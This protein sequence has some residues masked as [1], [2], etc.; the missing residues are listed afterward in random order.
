VFRT[1]RVILLAAVPLPSE[2]VA[3][4]GSTKADQ[5]QQ[6]KA[7]ERTL[8]DR[9]TGYEQARTEARDRLGVDFEK[10]ESKR[11]ELQTLRQFQ[12][13]LLDEVPW[14]FT[15]YTDGKPDKHEMLTFR[16]IQALVEAARDDDDKAMNK[17]LKAKTTAT[18]AQYTKALSNFTALIIDPL[19]KAGPPAGSDTFFRTYD[20]LT[21]GVKQLEQEVAGYETKL[22]DTTKRLTDAQAAVDAAA[23]T[24]AEAEGRLT[25]KWKLDKVILYAEKKEQPGGSVEVWNKQTNIYWKTEILTPTSVRN[26]GRQY[27]VTGSFTRP[28]TFLEPGKPFDVTFQ[29]SFSQ[30]EKD[31]GWPGVLLDVMGGEVSS[32]PKVGER[33]GFLKATIDGKEVPRAVFEVN[34]KRQNPSDR[35]TFTAPTTE[36]TERPYW[37]FVIR[38]WNTP[39]FVIA[40]Q[41]KK[42]K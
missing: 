33:L 15:R 22:G 8:A 39:G 26:L 36:D 5:E 27:L 35:F 24:L 6:R 18:L 10:Y 2:A 23:G 32:D 29:G 21:A 37:R 1:L 42:L 13:R 9:V 7:A 19:V 3:Q 30:S 31:V 17:D 28:P 12:R 14:V 40:Y 34:P 41:Y 16:Q 20:G 38:G 11:N 25:G 4:P